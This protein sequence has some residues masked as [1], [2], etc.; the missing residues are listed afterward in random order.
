MG[1][2]GFFIER[3]LNLCLK[4]DIFLWDLKYLD[5]NSINL[6]MSIKGFKMV[7]SA[8]YK[9]HSKVKIIKKAGLPFIIWK[10]KKRK[11]FIIGFVVA[12]FLFVFLSSFVWRVDVEGNEKINSQLLIDQLSECGFE[13]GD[14]RY[15]V[16]VYFLQNEMMK[17]NKDLAWF[18]LEIKGTR[19]VVKVKERVEAPEI[20][21]KTIPTN[22]V[23]SKKGLV[24]KVVALSGESV[25]KEGD[26][27]DE[28]DILISGI[29]D[30]G[31]KGFKSLN[32]RG[33]ILART[34]H[35]IDEEF[36]LIKTDYKKTDKKI[37]KSTVNFFGF[38]V[39][40]YL[41][42]KIPYKYFDVEKKESQFSLGKNFCLPIK[43]TKNT[44]YEK[45]KTET[46]LTE[47]V[48]LVYYGDR[49]KKE[50]E[51]TLDKNIEIINKSVE[52]KMLENGKIYV[53]VVYECIEDIAKTVII[54]NGGQ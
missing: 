40:L 21:D 11:G 6:K 51:N 50:L 23:A 16:D 28:G 48:A 54:E 3:F 12:V 35:S 22:V 18:W 31:E 5:E 27:V 19:A 10:Y 42:D 25:V 36:D 1:V 8:A 14:L 26:T 45:N 13:N 46:K 52:H 2:K 7:R 37:S 17:K 53:K 41:N 4:K 30:L 33:S 15:G 34:W 24:T 9:T 38:D 49:L 29:V 20:I 39:L 44:Y 32:S 43:I 47:D